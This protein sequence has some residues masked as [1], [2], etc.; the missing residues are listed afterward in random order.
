M[1]RPLSIITAATIAAL[2]LTAG[3]A[4]QRADQTLAKYIDE[5]DW[6]LAWGLGASDCWF[7]NAFR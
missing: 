4:A 5:Y 7:F 6:W 3:A 1:K 2:T